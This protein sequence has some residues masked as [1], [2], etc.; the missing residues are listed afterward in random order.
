MAERKALLH[1]ED[2]LRKEEAEV[3]IKREMERAKYRAPISLSF[4]IISNKHGHTARHLHI[5]ILF[6]FEMMNRTI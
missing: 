1:T 5:V 6:I 2:E 3:E 4:Y